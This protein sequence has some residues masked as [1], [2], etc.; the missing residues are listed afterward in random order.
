MDYTKPEITSLVSAS[1]VIQGNP[2][3]KQYGG[4]DTLGSLEFESIAAY[5]AD[6]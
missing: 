3:N 1:F 2:Q 4:K 5:E 6:E